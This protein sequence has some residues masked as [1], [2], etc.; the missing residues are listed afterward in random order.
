[1]TIVGLGMDA[2]E[3]PRIAESLER[4]GTRFLNRVFT[5]EEIAYCMRRKYPAQHLAGRFA[6]KEAGMKAIG[7][8]HAFG[9]LW[10]DLEVVRRGGPPQLQFHNAAGDHFRRLGATR[11]LVTITHT[12]TLAL[13]HVILV[14]DPA[15][16]R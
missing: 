4:Y 1:M 14:G 15:N 5:A 8:G 16:T 6:A 2:T 13:A 7:T 9:V 11:A 12:D 10:R 3:V